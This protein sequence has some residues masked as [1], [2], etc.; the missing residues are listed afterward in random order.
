MANYQITA[1][2][3]TKYQVTAPDSAT[4]DEVMA[5]VQAQHQAPAQPPQE[6]SLLSKAADM[7]S[8]VTGAAL[9]PG[10]TAL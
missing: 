2:D 5:H 1:P 9:F 6:P 7:A 8:N 10:A 4:Q 3:G